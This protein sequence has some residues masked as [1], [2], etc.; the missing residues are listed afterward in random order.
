MLWFYI[1]RDVG[2]R[3]IIS[4]IATVQLQFEKSSDKLSKCCPSSQCCRS[5][6]WS[7]WFSPFHPRSTRLSR[8]FRWTDRCLESAER[9]SVTKHKLFQ[10]SWNRWYSQNTSRRPWKLLRRCVRFARR[11]WIRTTTSTRIQI[12]SDPTTKRQPG[13]RTMETRLLSN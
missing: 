3:L 4:S 12:A 8:S 13:E 6:S 11:G 10:L 5:H 1:N 9:Q 7:C 2:L